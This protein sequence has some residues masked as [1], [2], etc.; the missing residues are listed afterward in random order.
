[1]LIVFLQFYIRLYSHTLES[2][3]H[4]RLRLSEDETRHI[5]F[6][7]VVLWKLEFLLLAILR[8]PSPV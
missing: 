2:A 8:K 1:M 4:C 6:L 7:E 3:E 5:F